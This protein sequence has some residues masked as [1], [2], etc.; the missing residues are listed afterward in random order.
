[1]RQ[2]RGFT[3]IEVMITLVIVAILGG[4]AIASYQGYVRESNRSVAWSMLLQIQSGEEKYFLQNGTYTADLTDAPTAGGLGLVLNL[5]GGT[6]YTPDG[7]Y[8]LAIA[9]VACA[10]GGGG[11]CSYTATANAANAQLKDTAACQT[12]T[13][14]SLGQRTP[15]DSTGCWR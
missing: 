12:F 7:N 2:L 14:T 1:M 5:S 3:L 6:L 9:T 10:G 8:S 13:I 4:L 15:A 11:L